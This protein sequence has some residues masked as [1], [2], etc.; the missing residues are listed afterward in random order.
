MP[1]IEELPVTGPTRVSHGWAYVPDT[2]P[3]PAMAPPGSRKRN[4]N[5]AGTTNATATAKQQKAVQQRLEGLDKENYKDNV[6]VPIPVKA[7]ANFRDNK[8][9]RKMTSNVRRILTYQR[10]FQHY[11]ADEEAGLGGAAAAAQ[12]STPNLQRTDSRR[13]SAI[14]TETPSSKLSGRNKRKE[15][16]VHTSKDQPS[17]TRTMRPPGRPRKSLQQEDIPVTDNE[18]AASTAESSHQ[19]IPPAPAPIPVSK[20]PYDPALDAHPL[21]RTL[22]VPLM[23][24]DRVMAALLSEPP[25]SYTGA[26]ATPLPTA[27]GEEKGALTN[28]VLVAK[29]PRHFCAL[30]GYWGKVKCRKCGEWTCGLMECWKGHEGVCVAMGMY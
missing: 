13:K 10:T 15:S 16:E 27:T 17:N 9:G 25:L 5:D 18:T 19:D 28:A 23:P 6:P 7:S 26:R 30:C 11:L 1:L 21:L 12:T 22:N 24:S 8:S 3:I 2:G 14:A 4:R 20:Q 29:P